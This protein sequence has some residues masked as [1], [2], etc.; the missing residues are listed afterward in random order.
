M[1]GVSRASSEHT[2]NPYFCLQ[3]LNDDVIR[4]VFSAPYHVNS[5]VFLCLE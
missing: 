5:G 1:I 4:Y 2:N 3:L